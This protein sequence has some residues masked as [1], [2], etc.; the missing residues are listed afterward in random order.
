MGRVLSSR[1]GGGHVRYP[2]DRWMSSV[3]PYTLFSPPNGFHREF[4]G[5]NPEQASGNLKEFVKATYY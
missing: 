1:K 3:Q 4:N 5:N 2:S